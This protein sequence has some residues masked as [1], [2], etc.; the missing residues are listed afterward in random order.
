MNAEVRRQEKVN[1]TK[2]RGF[3]QGELLEKYTTRI[4][5]KQND[6]KFEKKYL[7]KL[8]RN[9]AKWKKKTLLLQQLLAVIALV[10]CLLQ[11]SSQLAIQQWELQ[12][13]LIRSPCCIDPLF[14][15]QASGPCYNN[16]YLSLCS[17]IVLMS[18]YSSTCVFL[19]ATILPPC[20]L[21]SY[22]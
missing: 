21:M 20:A 6:E 1:I 2:E 22:S 17:C 9:W 5:Y 19:K 12:E 13:N 3:R 18:Y 14:I 4:L 16:N 11:Q 10:V 7:R 8:E 15:L